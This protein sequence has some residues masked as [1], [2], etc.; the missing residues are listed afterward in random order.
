MARTK[1]AGR[2]EARQRL[3]YARACVQVAD[4][5]LEDIDSAMPG[6]AAGLAVLAGIAASDAICAIRLGQIHRGENHRDAALL[7]REAV[8]DG[9]KLGEALKK[10]LDRKDE[11]H[12]GLTVVS[13]RRA[14]DSVRW[15]VFLVDR[16]TEEFGR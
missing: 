2:A 4:L 13:T 5:V 3:E 14:R 1:A 10:L 7:L 15:A 12:Y 6:V 9:R 16:A 8:P 11:A